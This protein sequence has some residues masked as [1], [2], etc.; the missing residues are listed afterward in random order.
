MPL[1]TKSSIWNASHTFSLYRSL[2]REATYLPDEAAQSYF[3]QWITFRFKRAA[4]KPKPD[5]EGFRKARR[6]LLRLQRANNGQTKALQW[7]LF[8]TYGRIGKRRREL[9]HALREYG[10]EHLFL[11][12]ESAV[13]NHL[14]NYLKSESKEKG[15]L[16]MNTK[17]QTLIA[18]QKRASLESLPR[19]ELKKIPDI[20]EFN[21]WK[22]P[23]PLKLRAGKERKLLASVLDKVL[24]PLPLHEHERLH[25]LA[26]GIIRFP[27]LP[28]R[29][30]SNQQPPTVELIS[31]KE[32]ARLLQPI[33]HVEKKSIEE[34]FDN[35]KITA[36][37]M[38]RHWMQVWS[39]CPV[40]A[41]N[42]TTKKWNVTWPSSRSLPA[43]DV[44]TTASLADLELFEGTSGDHQVQKKPS[45]FH[46]KLKRM[47]IPLETL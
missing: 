13:K 38:Q 10:D 6:A 26:T 14:E 41:Q 27:G 43:S 24:P 22:R 47:G 16:D 8:N 9:I 45:G 29:R 25:N 11:Q 5:E 36:R 28:P 33:E 42:E 20:P 44:V 19:A 21:A 18:S 7:V 32:I 31:E 3:R 30:S 4:S 34:S 23:L 35:H 37:H 1:P 15:I 39:L 2:L 12:D 17:L 40:M 46:K